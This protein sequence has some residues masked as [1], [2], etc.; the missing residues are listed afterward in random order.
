MFSI[1][2]TRELWNWK[3]LVELGKVC[4]GGAAEFDVLTRGIWKTLLWK[5]VV[6]SNLE[7]PFAV[8]LVLDEN[9]SVIV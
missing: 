5:T 3:H 7:V 2:L 1:Y 9:I 6:P 8:V 4:R